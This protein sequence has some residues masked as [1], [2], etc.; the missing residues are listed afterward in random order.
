MYGADSADL[1][2]IW[3]HQ[4]PLLLAKK[5]ETLNGGPQPAATQSL[6]L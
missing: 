6:L 2:E 1:G 3:H 4:Q 5:L